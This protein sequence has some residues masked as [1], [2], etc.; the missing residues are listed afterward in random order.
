MRGMG[1]EGG[2]VGGEGGG[3]GKTV[4][5]TFGTGVSSKRKHRSKD[6]KSYVQLGLFGEP[7]P[8]KSTKRKYVKAGKRAN[9]KP[10]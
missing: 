2:G 5:V 3:E 4:H 8:L 9:P 1:G 6:V 10:D 7:L